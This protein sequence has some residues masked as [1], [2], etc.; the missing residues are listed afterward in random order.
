MLPVKK[1]VERPV[2]IRHRRHLFSTT[3]SITLSASRPVRRWRLAS[4]GFQLAALQL[5]AHRNLFLPTSGL[6]QA[7]TITCTI[8]DC[9]APCHLC[10]TAGIEDNW[11]GHAGTAK[12]L[13]YRKRV[14]LF[15]AECSTCP[16]SKDMELCAT[17]QHLRLHHLLFCNKEWWIIPVGTLEDMEALQDCAF[18]RLLLLATQAFIAALN[19]PEPLAKTLSFRLSAFLRFK[20]SP[21]AG[22]R[23]EAVR[24]GYGH[25]C[26]TLSVECITEELEAPA[27]PQCFVPSRID[28]ER[29]MHWLDS[30]ANCHSHSIKQ[31]ESDRPKGI[32]PVGFR[33]IDV[34]E[35]RLTPLPAASRYVAL[36]YVWGREHVGPQ[37]I[38]QSSNIAMYE[39]VGGLST[40]VLP[41]VIE[42]ALQVCLRLKERYLWVDRFCIV[43]DD[44]KNKQEQIRC[45]ADIFTMATFTLVIACGDNMSV[46]LPG[47]GVD[48][49]AST[50]CADFEGLH[51][52]SGLPFLHDTI[53]ASTWYSRGWTYQEGIL[54]RR[55]LFITP[56]QVI[57]MCPEGLI[58]EDASMN[59]VYGTDEPQHDDVCH[60]EFQLQGAQTS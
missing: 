11:F 58:Y 23:L 22:L 20:R 12:K 18:H 26:N 24:E 45:M 46:Q 40:E 4:L 2:S 43:Q 7:H 54:A 34:Q 19:I 33:V 52:R 3:P 36:S 1:F 9:T 25:A 6:K 21:T 15:H 31:P 47:I 41:N 32:L 5:N 8:M 55:K 29:V 60:R 57:W 56:M 16:P 39:E 44:D 27:S 53:R 37:S 10:E 35:R 42:E 13:S 17:C 48:R 49:Y 28:F 59:R 38:S 51:V 50:D 14:E 30:C